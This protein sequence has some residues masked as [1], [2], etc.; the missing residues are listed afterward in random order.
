MEMSNM[1]YRTLEAVAMIP[2]GEY[3][4]SAYYEYL[5]VIY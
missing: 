1:I 2:K 3:N 5:N 4:S